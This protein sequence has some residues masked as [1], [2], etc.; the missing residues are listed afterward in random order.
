MLTN[1]EMERLLLQETEA[2]IHSDGFAFCPRCGNHR[3][4]PVATDNPYSR[5]V[6]GVL[7]CEACRKDEDHRL[8]TASKNISLK[9]WFFFA[10]L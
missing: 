4:K 7:I 6:A 1:S 10:A 8:R 2:F 5:Q 9:K 3:L